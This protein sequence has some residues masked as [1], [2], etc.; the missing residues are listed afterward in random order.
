MKGKERYEDGKERT[1]KM[2]KAIKKGFTLV[3]LVIVIAV[4]AVLSAVLIPVFGNVINDSKVSALKADLDTCSTRMRLYA[5]DKRV[6]YYT[7]AVARDV[8]EQMEIAGLYADGSNGYCIDGYS[9]WFNQENFNFIL[10][11]NSEI[12]KYIDRGG[13]T[14]SVSGGNTAAFAADIL[15]NVAAEGDVVQG[16]EKSGAS[17]KL[18]MVPR[19]P[20]AITANENLLLMATD[21]NNKSVLEAIDTMYNGADTDK[22]K[23]SAQEIIYAVTNSMD[24]S[25][26]VRYITNDDWKISDY[27]DK[28]SPSKT[29]WLN[30]AGNFIT[31]VS[32]NDSGTISVSN[33][34]V[35]R[36]LGTAF[37]VDDAGE[38][39]NVDASDRKIYGTIRNFVGTNLSEP[40]NGVKGAKLQI[41]CVL[42]IAS[43][44]DIE[45]GDEFYQKFTDSVV[46]VMYSGKVTM[47]ASSSY[48]SGTVSVSTVT[49][50]SSSIG[51]N[52]SGSTSSGT[53]SS[54]DTR[55]P[56]K[57]MD[58]NVFLNWTTGDSGTGTKVID[59]STVSTT[60]D[61]KTKVSVRDAN[62]KVQVIEVADLN[63]YFKKSEGMQYKYNTTSFSID[64]TGFLSKLKISSDEQ[65]KSIKIEDYTSNGTVFATRVLLR[66]LDEKGYTQDAR[67]NFGVG[68]ITSFDHYYRYYNPAFNSSSNSGENS[69][70]EYY[71]VSETS[72]NSGSITVKLPEGT[73]ELQSYKNNNYEIEVYYNEVTKYYTQ[74]KSEFGLE[75]KKYSHE[76]T[77]ATEK[78]AKWG[79]DGQKVNGC[80]L[81]DF[82]THSKLGSQTWTDPTTNKTTTAAYFV[83]TVKINRIVIKEKGENG[84]ILLVK[85]PGQ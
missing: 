34:I 31:D 26:L 37:N 19:R 70:P 16:I 18:K 46:R 45:I 25:D 71:G 17:E 29:A 80:S 54:S 67:F 83:N 68:Y 56:S 5:L 85:Y 59:Y 66:Y 69:K 11:K 13:A 79:S 75:Y 33:V 77:G 6:D 10:V 3:E 30:N 58:P 32:A 1:M 27:T 44:T 28:F 43:E 55:I 23:G 8:L 36:R 65:V 60:E 24:S 40:S 51:N 73:T 21:K 41:S 50:N 53:G 42:E 20:E 47:T 35:S 64:V 49:G 84:K 2:I 62:G 15:D 81:I 82:G 14:A 74:E 78:V 72:A 39:G 9:I 52:G 12:S 76:E 61:G 7:P 63:E 57:T 4:I 48:T 22:S 38:S